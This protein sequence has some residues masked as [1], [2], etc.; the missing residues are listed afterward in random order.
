MA[1]QKERFASYLEQKVSEFFLREGRKVLPAE[2][3]ISVTRVIP[4]ESGDEAEI[5]V[6]IFPERLSREI[7]KE[8]RHMGSAARKF[9]ADK[10]KRRK[11]PNIVFKLDNAQER[12]VRLEKLLEKVKNE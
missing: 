10:I 4:N 2:A 7:F 5:F 8:V 12:E 9:L 3:F 11:I 1:Y 6:L